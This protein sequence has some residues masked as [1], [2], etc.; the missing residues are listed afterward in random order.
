MKLAELGSVENNSGSQ[1][2]LKIQ[3]LLQASFSSPPKVC[4]AI[5]IPKTRQSF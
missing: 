5:K 4:C 2:G 3:M 1:N